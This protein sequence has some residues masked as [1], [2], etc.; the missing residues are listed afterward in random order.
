VNTYS[1]VEF[2]D[3]LYGIYAKQKAHSHMSGNLYS[4]SCENFIKISEI[5]HKF[6]YDYSLVKYKNITDVIK[7]ICKKHGIFETRGCDHLNNRLGG[8]C[9]ECDEYSYLKKMTNF[10]KNKSYFII[11]FIGLVI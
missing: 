4:L 10:L 2:Y 6:K 7:I 11:N 5:N 9:K 1:S 8:S 3:K